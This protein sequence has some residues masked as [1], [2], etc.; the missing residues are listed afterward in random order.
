MFS[1][2]RVATP[3]SQAADK[4]TIE[5]RLQGRMNDVVDSIKRCAVLCESYQ[6]RYTVG[7]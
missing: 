5:Q 3:K 1:L 7:E 6:N 4:L 2:K